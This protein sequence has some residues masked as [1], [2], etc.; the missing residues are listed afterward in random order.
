[1]LN[2]AAPMGAIEG[3]RPVNVLL[4]ED[5]EVSRQ[6]ALEV[7][8]DAGHTVSA[9]S[10]GSAALEALK[11]DRFDV[12]VMDRHMP[13]M[14]GI[15]ATREIRS[16]EEPGCTVPIIGI[17]AGVTEAELRE[18][19]DAGMNTVLKK[20]IE[21]G[22]L[23]AVVSRLTEDRQKP[24][25]VVPEAPILVVDDVELNRSVAA[26]QLESLGLAC[27]LAED[28]PSALKLLEETGFA[29]ALIDVA[30]PGMD[31]MELTEFIRQREAVVGGR[32]PVIAMTGMTSP[33]DRSRCL[34]AGMDDL[35]AK[36]VILDEL[37]SVLSRWL[38]N[39]DSTSGER[40]HMNSRQAATA[41][42]PI[43]EALLRDIRGELD[44]AA[45]KE[46]AGQFLAHFEPILADLIAAADTKDP[47][48]IADA[49]HKCKSAAGAIAAMRLHAILEDLEVTARS[50]NAIDLDDRFASIDRETKLIRSIAGDT[51]QA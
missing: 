16:G 5:D 12:V 39:V 20:P 37:S 49:A 6:V 45:M 47:I 43:D 18:C 38:T 48:A 42:T 30:M 24:A 11:Q 23:I 26:H 33:E 13:V 9:V 27:Q 4:A 1:M 3:G 10:D 2:S 14:G 35:I 44:P 8:E 29:A 40:A 32:M 46:L 50:S 28:G 17:T 21:A 34:D 36:P 15:A 25:L 51:T 31:G 19:T 41:D 22:E 7:L